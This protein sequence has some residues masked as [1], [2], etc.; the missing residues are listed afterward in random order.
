MM[1]AFY[2][3]GL[4]VFW[5]ACG[6]INVAGVQAFSPS[7]YV[8]FHTCNRTS[9]LGL[10]FGLGPIL[11]VIGLVLLLGRMLYDYGVA[12]PIVVCIKYGT[13][14]GRALGRLINPDNE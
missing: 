1:I 4:I 3:L 11:T 7:S 8:D 2:L 12:R 10:C 13:R 9:T 14:W 6:V 5:W